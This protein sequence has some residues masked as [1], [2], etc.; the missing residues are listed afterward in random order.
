MLLSLNLSPN[1]NISL[2]SH[3]LESQSDHLFVLMNSQ[4]TRCKDTQMEE[5]VPEAE[6]NAI[7]LAHSLV[8]WE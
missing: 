6:E 7:F 1:P 4:N 2:C 8:P 3:T 5:D